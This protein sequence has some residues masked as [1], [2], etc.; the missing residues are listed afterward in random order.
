MSKDLFLEDLILA[1]ESLIEEYDIEIQNPVYLERA[2]HELASHILNDVD[3]ED[4]DDFIEYRDDID[5][6][7]GE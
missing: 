6:L 4:E 5:D 1:V 7:F 2:V 3:E